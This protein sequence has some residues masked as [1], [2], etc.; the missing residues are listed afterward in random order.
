AS[1]RYAMTDEQVAAFADDGGPGFVPG[2]FEVAAAMFRGEPKIAEAFR[3][4]RGVGWH[5]HDACLFRGIERFFRP[6]YRANL[7]SSWLPAL[8]GVTAKLERGA[9]VADI[10]CGH[11]ASTVIMAEAFPRSRFVGFDSHRASVEQAREAA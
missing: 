5:E 2:A 7:L 4:G 8:D 10:G 9:T 3:T 6:G 1:G 11:G